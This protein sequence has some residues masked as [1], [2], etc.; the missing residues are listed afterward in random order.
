MTYSEELELKM[1]E[2]KDKN[3]LYNELLSSISELS[4]KLDEAKKNKVVKL[5]SNRL[6]YNLGCIAAILFEC[7]APLGGVEDWI[8]VVLVFIFSGMFQV[9]QAKVRYDVKNL[10][11]ELEDKMN[12]KDDLY[13][14][15]SILRSLVHEKKREE[16]RVS[17]LDV[18]YIQ[19]IVSEKTISLIK[20]IR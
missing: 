16:D 19:S 11:L 12:T 10:E 1:Q 13:N 8:G 9:A 7:I 14:E 4:N 17:Y 18:N 6:N 20:T 5:N 3:D 2:L 15:V